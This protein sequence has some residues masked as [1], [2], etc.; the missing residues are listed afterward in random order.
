MLEKVNK[1]NNGITY[2]QH[3]AWESSAK[4]EAQQVPLLGEEQ[5][6]QAHWQKEEA[7]RRDQ[8]ST[9]ADNVPVENL[10]KPQIRRKRNTYWLEDSKA[11]IR[12][13]NPPTVGHKL[14]RPYI[15]QSKNKPQVDTIAHLWFVFL[16]FSQDQVIVS[17]GRD[18]KINKKVKNKTRK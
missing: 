18:N 13:V 2:R 5:R 11:H 14:V 9:V 6:N 7:P 12:D 1:K 10:A 16:I 8:S 4:E 15:G 17:L 3:L